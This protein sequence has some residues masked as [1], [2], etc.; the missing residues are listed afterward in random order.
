M[1]IEDNIYEFIQIS[2]NGTN[3]YQTIVNL[4]DFSQML[5]LVI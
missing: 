1:L 4:S 2:V 3:L 5:P